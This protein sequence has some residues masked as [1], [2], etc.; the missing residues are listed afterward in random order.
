MNFA[1]R[2]LILTLLI[3]ILLTSC[4]GQVAAG[5]PTQDINAT[6]A[7]AAQ[8]F[9]ASLF[10]TQTALAPTITNTVPPT[11]TPPPTDNC[12]GAA[13]ANCFRD[14]ILFREYGDTISYRD[15]LHGYPKSFHINLWM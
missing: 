15:F 9:A 4:G 7:V 11:G 1:R 12:T 14:P 5:E 3:T 2:S 10:Q 8:T 6:V 13:L